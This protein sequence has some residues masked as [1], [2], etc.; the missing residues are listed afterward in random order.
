MVMRGYVKH[1]LKN[2]IKIDP[3]YQK[4]ISPRKVVVP[5]KLLNRQQNLMF[6]GRR[7]MGYHIYAKL[8]V[9]LTTKANPPVLRKL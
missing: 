8:A 4:Y 1:A 7:Y 2:T 5:A 9:P 6:L 3:Y